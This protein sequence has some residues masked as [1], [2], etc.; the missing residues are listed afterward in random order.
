MNAPIRTA[1]PFD[2]AGTKGMV[3]VLDAEGCI[4]A[5]NSELALFFGY[6]PEDL[7]QRAFAALVV[8]EEQDNAVHF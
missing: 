6:A 2:L 4:Q 8:P 3:A 1:H 7:L 5:A